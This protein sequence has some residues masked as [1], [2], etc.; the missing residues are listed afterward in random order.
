[1]HMIIFRWVNYLPNETD[2]SRNT[3]AAWGFFFSL[4]TL[5]MTG[6]WRHSHSKLWNRHWLVWKR[7]VESKYC[8]SFFKEGVDFHYS[9]TNWQEHRT[10]LRTID[11]PWETGREMSIINITTRIKAFL[12]ICL[13][14]LREEL[15]PLSSHLVLKGGILLE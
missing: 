15:W 14:M 3:S 5:R 13:F 7:R 4:L 12:S 8:S 11:T 6:L 1:M 10:L 2:G 9:S